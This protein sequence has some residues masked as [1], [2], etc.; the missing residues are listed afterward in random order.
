M[1]ARC[2][3]KEPLNKSTKRVQLRI[4]ASFFDTHF[5]KLGLYPLIPEGFTAATSAHDEEEEGHTSPMGGCGGGAVATL[6]RIN[7]AS[8]HGISPPPNGNLCLALHSPLT[9]RAAMQRSK[10]N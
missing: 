6:T 1:A 8:L 9:I 2:I 5:E 3:V 7:F 10:P 4:Q